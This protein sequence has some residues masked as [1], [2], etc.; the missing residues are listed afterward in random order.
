M[1][2]RSRRTVIVFVVIVAAAILG[3]YFLKSAS[4]ARK[5]ADVK[6]PGPV[7][8]EFAPVEER[9]WG[10][11]VQ[12]VGTVQSF[13]G[14]TLRAQIG[15]RV[16]AVHA[17]SGSSVKAGDPLFEINPKVIQAQLEE[18]QA[19]LKITKFN[20]ER[21]KELYAER[22]V[23]LQDL[24]QAKSAYDVDVAKVATSQQQL[25]LATT[26]ATFD[27]EVGVTQV[28]VG[29]EVDVN[30]ELATL[31]SS[32]RLRVEFSVPQK[33]ASLISLQDSVSLTAERGPSESVE[34][35]VF[36]I[37]PLVDQNTRTVTVRAEVP[38]HRFLPGSYVNVQLSLDDASNVL[39][40][41]QTAVVHS[42]YGDSVFK[43]VNG[44]AVQTH[45]VPGTQR[46]ADIEVSGKLKAGDQVVS[47][48]LRKVKD[49]AAVTGAAA[50]ASHAD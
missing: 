38:A 1:S 46:G 30:Q 31:Q 27:G 44:K 14:I 37:N 12:S 47:A 16:T 50:G 36:A 15:G 34:A 33:Y 40:V 20:Y 9:Q 25:A 43:V 32:E 2:N 4:N 8:V 45:V 26:Y 23:S 21:M 7:Y 49:G 19:A 22:N 35:R 24:T 39:T 13:S 41:P 3:I 6:P 29:D 11:L 48:G 28:E 17:R 5:L 10:T 42:L 18:N